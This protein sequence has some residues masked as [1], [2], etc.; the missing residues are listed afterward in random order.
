[1]TGIAVIPY[2]NPLAVAN[3]LATVDYLSGGR[4]DIGAGVGWMKEEFD[5]LHVPYEERGKIIGRIP[6]NS[7][8]G[9]V[10]EKSQ[11]QR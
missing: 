3:T 11:L 1:M 8:S 10:R 9:L 6:A 2:R 4:L 7:Q 5:L